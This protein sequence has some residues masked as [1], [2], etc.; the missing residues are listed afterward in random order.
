VKIY[1]SIKELVSAVFRIGVR[2]VTVN[3]PAAPAA[4]RT[5]TLP[6]ATDTLVGRDMVQT[7]T[8]KTLTSPAITTPTGIVKADVGLGNVDNTS[9]ATKNSASVTLSNKTLLTPVI[10]DYFDLNEESA[11][12]TPAS[13]KVR[14]YAKTDNKLYLKDDLGTETAVGS[15]GSGEIN[16]I[17]TGSTDA[18]GW[19]N[20]T[21]HTGATDTS[22]SPLSPVVTTAISALSSA[23]ISLGSQTSTS[24][25]YKAITLPTGLENKKLKVEFYFTSP[26]AADGTWAL[27]VYN[28]T[29][30][31]PLT[32]DS[33]G[34]TILPAGT[35][36]KFTAYFDTDSN[37]SYS[38]NIVQR[39]RTN[40]NTLYATSVVV[41]PGIQPQ[42]AVVGDWQSYTPTFNNVTITSNTSY[43]RRVGSSIEVR[44]EVSASAD[45]T[46]QVQ[47]NLVGGI[48]GVTADTAAF[49]TRH[50][51]G[52]GAA[53][54]GVNAYVISP[55]YSGSATY[56]AFRIDGTAVQL[57]ASDPAADGG[58]DSGDR[59]TFNATFPIAE[60]AGSGT[61]NVAQND[62]EW[63]FSTNT[64]T[65]AG[66]TQTD[67]GLY[68]YGPI[69]TQFVAID[70]VTLGSITR[71]RV[72]FQTPIQTGDV[73]ELEFF[74]DN[75]WFSVGQ[76]GS[77]AIP[78]AVY[79][80]APIGASLESIVGSSTDTYVLFGNAGRTIG[81]TFG[82][83]GNTWAGIA[84][85]N[86]YKWRVRK[87]SAGAANGFG[88]ANA[89]TSGLISAESG[90]LQGFT[91]SSIGTDTGSVTAFTTDTAQYMTIGKA[92]FI[93][94]R[95][96]SITVS[97]SP[98]EFR[99]TIPA[100][101]SHSVNPLSKLP[102]TM[103]PAGVQTTGV[104]NLA[105]TTP[106]TMVFTK[107]DASAF[108]G[109]S[110]IHFCGFIPIS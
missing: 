3:P 94:L 23:A 74:A 47:W 24:G 80:N 14:V 25:V 8:N 42:G 6:D 87:S 70:S 31:V 21:S 52:F 53:L 81:G 19:T 18:T 27:A 36:G 55:T 45:A 48:P 83:A 50:A 103:S 64:V 96:V 37:N 98:T 15:G 66:N 46:G 63:A 17:T 60:W 84:G 4:D 69:G 7:L 49:G 39:T 92:M 76:L 97:G 12:G 106:T 77:L 5:I 51:L 43:W 65:T 16:A 2:Q 108:T 20:G 26:A 82:A 61:V 109:T 22:N 71:K 28:S 78:L 67:D 90:A 73:I 54:L 1:G 104:L 89:T 35:T 101:K 107:V 99:V 58:F 85:S 110:Q 38:V 40:A 72:R 57:G 56:A 30:R 93:S 86:L 75:G 62:V 34:D 29:T 79:N 33:S 59:L 13:G 68:G 11:P 102:A 88:L 95:L 105:S 10:D 91:V 32:T 9:D 44:V 41:G 100:S